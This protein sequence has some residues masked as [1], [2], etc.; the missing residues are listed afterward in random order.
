MNPIFRFPK[1]L[2][3]AL[4][5]M[6]V[7]SSCQD[8]ETVTP[9]DSILSGNYNEDLVLEDRV[10]NPNQPD[11]VVEGDVT[12]YAQLTIEPG[13]RVE[14]D[15]NTALII[16]EE[17]SVVAEGTS[18]DPIVLTGATQTAGFW[19][20]VLIYSA[21][22]SNTLEYVTISYAGGNPVSDIWFDI[23]AN[24]AIDNFVTA[25]VNINNCTF[26]NS[27]GL[28]MAGDKD[29]DI[30]SFSNNTFSNNAEAALRLDA[31]EIGQLDNASDFT[32]GNGFDGVEVWGSNVDELTAITWPSLGNGAPY[33]ILDDITVYSGVNVEPGATFRFEPNSA[34]IVEEDAYFIADGNASEI[35]TFTGSVTSAPSWR[36]ILFYSPDVRNKL[37]YCEVSFAGSDPVSD[38]WYDIKANVA[39][40]N[41]ASGY[42]EVTNCTIR[43][44]EGCGLAVDS[45]ATLLQSGNTFSNLPGGN[46][47]N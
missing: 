25:K 13:V 19:R 4:A 2:F 47:C 28:G 45:G 38:I 6:A 42:L 5:T 31:T 12:L 11:Y 22:V 9:A 3:L 8:D 39:V 10:N 18:S 15:A 44:G 16:E 40:D 26:S 21:N 34:L 27:A 24:L 7:W 41:Y 23:K 46:T 35:I 33:R 36:G 37:S 20:G 1:F 14:F 17:G 43:D 32:D 29:I 30:V